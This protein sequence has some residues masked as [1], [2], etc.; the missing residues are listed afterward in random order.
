MITGERAPGPIAQCLLWVISRR[1][2]ALVGGP[3]LAQ[4]RTWKDGPYPP[5]PLGTFH[6]REFHFFEA[7][8]MA[9]NPSAMCLRVVAG[10]GAAASPLIAD[11]WAKSAAPARSPRLKMRRGRTQPGRGRK[12]VP[13]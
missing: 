2:A 10:G 5:T 3:L 4:H 6:L 11:H 7:G 9:P 12:G 1:Q 13:P 8:L